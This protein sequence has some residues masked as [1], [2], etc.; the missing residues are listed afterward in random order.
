MRQTDY[1]D[2]IIENE[3]HN[4]NLAGANITL[5]QNDKV[6]YRRSYGMADIERSIPMSHNT[7]F[8]LF[9]MS[10]PVTTVAA[11][12]L[13]ERGIID[14]LDPVSKYLPTYQNQMVREADGTLRPA[15]T[16]MLLRDLL[17][18]TS[19]LSYPDAT[20]IGELVGGVFDKMCDGQRK[21]SGTRTVDL[22]L[23][24]GKLPLCYDPGTHWQYSTSADVLGAVIEIASK[25]RFS[26]FLEKEIFAPLGMKDTGFYV[27]N[28]KRD[29]FAQLYRCDNL[30]IRPEDHEN[31]GI[32]E[33]Y[34]HLP[35]FES[36]GAGLVSTIDDYSR[37]ATMLLHGGT[38]N[39][40]RILSKRSVEFMRTP[41]LDYNAFQADQDWYSLK[42]YNYGN[43]VR[44]MERPCDNGAASVIGEYG[45]DGWVGTYFI[46]NP[47]DNF[48]M[49]YFINRCDTGC[50]DVTRKL[51]SIAYS[52]IS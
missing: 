39:G 25:M 4:N 9:S 52:L 15:K 21:G 10:K 19:G 13:M 44:I 48:I 27:P 43:L 18:M 1:L 30:G 23:E 33:L 5:I 49:L 45:W 37:F 34:D 17:N 26:E 3:I 12:I 8:R 41:A 38:Y 28:D 20:P 16:T 24:L 6:L 14:L 35:N 46:I 29:R 11:L 40:I 2:R 32:E 22:A 47:A 50:N 51:K 31:L 36:G 7:I 42:G